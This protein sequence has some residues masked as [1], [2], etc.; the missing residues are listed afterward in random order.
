MAQGLEVQMRHRPALDP[1]FLPAVLWNRAYH[2]GVR[3]T[4]GSV[5]LGIALVRQDGTT[6]THRT[7]ILPP[8]TAHAALNQ[9]YVERLVKLLLWQKGGCT[10]LVKG[11]DAVVRMLAAAYSE[12]GLRAFDWDL[13]GRRMFGQRIEVKAVR[14]KLPTA[15]ETSQPLG[16]HLEGCRIGFDLGG[17]DRKCAA[18]VDGKVV[19][20]DEV[21]WNP[22]FEKDPFYHLQGINDT[23]R[24]AAAHLPRVD[25]IGGSA[26]GV[27]VNSEPRVGSLYRGIAEPDFDRHIR[28]L[29]RALQSWWGG[30]PFE[31]VN[32]GEVTALAGSMSMRANAVLG[33]SM[34][35]SVAAGYVTRDG[36]IT[37]WLNELAF[38]PVD[39]RDDAPADEWSGDIGC[40]VQYFSQ[41]AVNRL[42]PAAGIEVPAEMPVA[43]RLVAVQKLMAGGDGRARRIYETIGTCY[44]YAIAHYA[45]H[46]DIQNMLVLGRVTSGEGGEVILAG[47]RQV[48]K[49]EFP[50]LAEKIRLRTPDEKDKRHGQAIAAAS[51]P[52]VSRPAARA[53]RAGRKK[54]R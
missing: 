20:S 43:E 50:A 51:L 39:Y 54:K 30:V 27:Y 34:G 38:V 31:V 9:K 8:T 53:A 33:Y 44:G 12:R 14:G 49:D 18:V 52:V 26:A 19:F 32:D 17:S 48:L 42:L 11:P 35:T 40:G 37:P 6:F 1:G 25:A 4:A 47:A 16:R 5:E 21:V 41:Q 10:I 2:A 45:D 22:Y 28:G 46:Y 23:L 13:V 15:R 36:N 24:R 7:R 3:A 29:F